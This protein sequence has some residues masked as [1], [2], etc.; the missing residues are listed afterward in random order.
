MVLRS[1]IQNKLDNVLLPYGITSHHLRRVDVDK[2]NVGGRA[3]AVNKDEYV[4][5]RIVS[6]RN[7]HG[8]GKPKISRRFVDVNYYYSY[9]KTDAR[10][11]DVEKRIKAIK[12]AF[13][14]DNAFTLANDESDLYD[15]DNPYRGINVEFMFAGV[16]DDVD[17]NDS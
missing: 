2:I 11:E 6:S 16:Y 13:L 7:K 5:F 3:V 15:L 17:E 10:F 12:A 9:D 4:V 1:T 8:D 14:S